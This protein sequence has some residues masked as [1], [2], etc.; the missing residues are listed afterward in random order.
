MDW[1]AE[2]ALDLHEDEEWL[3][4]FS[5]SFLIIIP[6]CSIQKSAILLKSTLSNLENIFSIF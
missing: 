1:A 2:T 5:I 3:S 6:S 4:H